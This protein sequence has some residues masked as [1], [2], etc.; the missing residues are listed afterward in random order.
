MSQESWTETVKTFREMQDRPD[1]APPAGGRTQVEP[2]RLPL[3]SCA[4]T[5]DAKGGMARVIL[6]QRFVNPHAEPLSV[7]YKLPLPEDGAVSDFGFTVADRRVQGVVQRTSDARETYERALASGRSAALLEQ[8]RA[9]LFVQEIGN[10]PPGQALEVRITIDQPLAWLSDASHEGTWEWRFPLAAAPRYLGGDSGPDSPH[11][12]AGTTTARASLALTVR[13]VA[14]SSPESTTHPLSVASSAAGYAIGLGSG[15]RVAL[16][17]DVVVRWTVATAALSTALDVRGEGLRA[18]GLLTVVPPARSARPA[19]VPRDLTLLLDTSGSMQGEPLEQEKRIACALIEGLGPNDT[20]EVIEFSHE[21]RAFQKHPQN[22]TPA[23][24]RSATAWVR[25]LSASGGTEMVSGIVAAMREL[26]PESQRQIVLVTDGLVGFEAQIVTEVLARL[27]ARARLHAVGVGSAVNRSLVAPIARAGRGIEAVVGL[28]EDA[29][30]TAQRVLS[31]TGDP[32]AVDLHVEG[33]A[34][35]T[36]V[37]AR[38][39]DVFTGSPLRVAL[40]LEPRGGEVV[41]RGRTAAG[42]FEQRVQVA[43]IAADQGTAAVAKLFAR[44][45]V[46]DCEMRRSGGEPKELVE[47]E[48]ERVGL[49]FQIA[50]CMT[51]WV[52]ATED[53]TVD[54][55]APSR[56]VVQPHALPYGTSA[57]GLGLRSRSMPLMASMPASMTT[58]APPP[59]G[60]AAPRRR[61]AAPMAGSGAPP[62]PAR[63]AAGFPAPPAAPKAAPESAR[64]LPARAADFLRRA[65]GGAKGESRSEEDAAASL[66]ARITTLSTGDIVIEFESPGFELDYATLEMILTLEGGQELRV[67]PRRDQSTAPG[68]VAAGLRIRIVLAAPPANLTRIRLVFSSLHA[69]PVIVQATR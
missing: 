39:P 12:S 48:I 14:T 57:E 11:F 3:E 33:S 10:V 13:D 32:Q 61:L 42:S 51:S 60:A 9:S 2:G 18:F 15:N 63:P 21:T 26:R 52:A 41:I 49:E 59:M 44:E 19:S 24:K 34:V 55:R 16:D 38:V 6:T 35:R 50:T 36:V 47:R 68:L 54:P 40:E 45:Q 22:V 27:P 66:P 4:L 1:D 17:R 43:P 20:L 5:V 28:G 64:S 7:T 30:R 23:L 29:E 56:H 46:E 8:E 65:V 25:A 69:A 31:R 58:G 62:V 53:A 37:P 67:P